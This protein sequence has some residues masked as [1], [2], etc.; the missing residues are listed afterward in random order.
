MNPGD[1]IDLW[2]GALTVTAT[3][4]GPFVLAMLAVGIVVAVFQT[5]TQL[6]E[7]VLVFAPKLA[8]AAIIVLLAGHW[9]LDRLQ[10]Y[11]QES[12]GHAAAAQ[13]QP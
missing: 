4:V 7:S 11:T 8:A 5:A 10:L 3:V 6:Q 12:F 1:L 13:V 9:F 2:R